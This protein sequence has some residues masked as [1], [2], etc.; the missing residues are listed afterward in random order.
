MHCNTYGA[1]YVQRKKIMYGDLTNY[2]CCNGDTCIS[3]KLGEKSC[4]EFCL[5]V[6]VGRR[7]KL[8]HGL[9]APLISSPPKFDL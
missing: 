5:C 8:V 3:G 9:K 4:P 7:C 1:A 2:T 6:E